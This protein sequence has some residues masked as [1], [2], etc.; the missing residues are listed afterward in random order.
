MFL[1]KSRWPK[2]LHP[3]VTPILPSTPPFPHPT[4]PDAG[5]EVYRDGKRDKEVGLQGW[6]RDKE[7]VVGSFLV[8]LLVLINPIMPRGDEPDERRLPVPSVASVPDLLSSDVGQNLLKPL[9]KKTPHPITNRFHS[10]NH[11]CHFQGPM[12][13]LRISVLEI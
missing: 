1:Q 6:E 4:P 7:V 3:K 9:G 2:A 5:S 12:G 11:C 13:S 8:R 10:K